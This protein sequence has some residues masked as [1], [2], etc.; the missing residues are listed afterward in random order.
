[1]VHI[2]THTA[3][4]HS[5]SAHTYSM[6]AHTHTHTSSISLNISTHSPCQ[7]NGK[8]KINFRAQQTKPKSIFMK[9]RKTVTGWFKLLCAEWI[10]DKQGQ[11]VKSSACQLWMK[12]HK[13]EKRTWGGSGWPFK[14]PTGLDFPAGHS[15]WNRSFPRSQLYVA[16]EEKLCWEVNSKANKMSYLLTPSL[17]GG[18]G[19]G[20]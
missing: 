7:D 17:K 19:A 3:Q 6:H 10:K 9:F 11:D 5:E 12:W 4:V 2:C 13:E 15:E 18:G 14:S 20:I 16:K 8:G 1:M